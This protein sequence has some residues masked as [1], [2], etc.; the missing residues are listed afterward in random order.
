V[1]LGRKQIVRTGGDANKE[2]LYKPDGATVIQKF[3]LLDE[4][5]NPTVGPN[6]CDV[7]PTA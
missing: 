6:I 1:T 2:I 5:G 7:V 3:H 4:N